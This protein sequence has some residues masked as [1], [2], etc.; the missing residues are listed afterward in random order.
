MFVRDWVAGVT[1]RANVSS[2]G[3]Q[4]NA[5]TFRGSISGDGSRVAFR[6][7]AT[8]FV[9]GDTNGALDVFEHDLIT[10]VTKRISVATTGAQADGS[11]FPPSARAGSF[12]SRAF[13]SL[14]GR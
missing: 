14:T 13:L 1:E 3:E 7:R 6:S 10:G 11:M 9:R 5:E 8:N 2:S 12:M 4:A